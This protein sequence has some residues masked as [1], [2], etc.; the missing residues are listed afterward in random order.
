MHRFLRHF[1][2]CRVLRWQPVGRKLLGRR[3]HRWDSKHQQT[4]VHCRFQRLGHW[5]DIAHDYNLWEQRLGGSLG[6]CIQ[7][8]AEAY[9]PG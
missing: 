7:F 3:K 9:R 4:G 5:E 1:D 8:S 2:Y 6:F